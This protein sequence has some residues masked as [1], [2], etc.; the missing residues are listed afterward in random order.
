MFKLS[1]CTISYIDDKNII[2]LREG[3]GPLRT[4]KG[5]VPKGMGIS[6][7]VA[8]I[9]LFDT[10]KKYIPNGGGGSPPEGVPPRDMKVAEYS[11]GGGGLPKGVP[12]TGYSGADVANPDDVD[13]V[14]MPGREEFP[15]TDSPDT[16]PQTMFNQ[17][18]PMLEGSSGPGV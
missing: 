6:E 12:P 18:S 5:V 10:L 2:I 16:S 14:E 8:T 13:D 11:G 1:E 7:Q 17:L 3:E 15:A 4:L 9:A